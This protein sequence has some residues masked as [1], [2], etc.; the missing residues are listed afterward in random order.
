M[1]PA[2]KLPG[3]SLLASREKGDKAESMALAYLKRQGLKAKT[4]NYR[5]KGG[6]I[7]L[8]MQDGQELVFVEVRYRSNK[9]FGGAAASVTPT[10]Q[11]RIVVAAQHYLL[12]LNSTPACRFDVV[13]IDGQ[14]EMDW[15]RNAFGVDG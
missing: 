1:S 4:R 8:I 6:E 5:C 12:S 14:G 3:L 13:A 10:K 11:K 2:I 15:I 9:D 7:D